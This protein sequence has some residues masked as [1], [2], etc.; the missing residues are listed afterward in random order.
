MSARSRA[1]AGAT[2][3]AMLA[4]PAAADPCADLR[5]ALDKAATRVSDDFYRLLPELAAA[6]RI[7]L[8]TRTGWEGARRAADA[9][10]DSVRAALHLVEDISAIEL[11]NPKH[12]ELLIERAF[13]AFNKAVLA[14]EEVMYVA[15]C[16]DL[17]ATVRPE[18]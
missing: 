16:L 15:I 13:R 3:L 4:G 6:R 1:L 10:D 9:A 5:G 7:A 2:I 17:P 8:E 11:P 14:F 12:R 18:S